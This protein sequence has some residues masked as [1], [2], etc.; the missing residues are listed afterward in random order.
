MMVETAIRFEDGAGYERM[1]GVWSRLVGEVFLDWLRRPAGLNWVDIGCGNGAFTAQLAALCGP[2]A[3]TGIDPSPAQLAYARGL[4]L[5][6]ARF[7]Q[8]DAMA[9]PYRDGEFD[10][11]VSAL[12]IFFMPDPAKGVR[13]MAR[14][15]RPGGTVCTYAWDLLGGGFPYEPVH[16]PL[17][18]RG[19]PAPLPPRVEA[20]E[21]AVLNDL[22]AGAGLEAVE[23]RTITVTRTFPDFEDFWGAALLTPGL[24][25][26]IGG[27]S[28][29]E[30]ESL[31]DEVRAGVQVSTSGT[32]ALTARAHAVKGS[33]PA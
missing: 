12:V 15:V 26:M 22:W 33:K 3:L 23:T 8:G 2:S 29:S 31:K 19:T 5:D 25:A 21:L 14:V 7:D 28:P 13:E 10:A 11:A 24:N 18:A 17:R 9:L 4:G 20:A 27:L 30:V 1:M 16:R 6:N 32:L